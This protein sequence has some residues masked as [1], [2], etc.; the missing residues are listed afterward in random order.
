MKFYHK[1][2][3]LYVRDMEG[4]K[5][6]IEGEYASPLIKMLKDVLWVFT[7]KIDGTNIGIHWDGNKVSYIGRTEKSNIPAYLIN[8]LDELFA[9]EENE[10]VFEQMFGEQKVTLFGEGYGGKIQ[11]GGHYGKKEDFIL[12]DV[13]FEEKELWAKR[14]VVQEIAKALNIGIV[15]I[16]LTGTL[17]DGV[18]YVKRGPKSNYSEKIMEGVVGRPVCEL[19]DAQGKRV[20]VKIKGRDFVKP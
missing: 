10:Q 3:T 2:E 19:K 11:N 5:K 8:R 6:L 20:I 14:G 7:E 9:G 15:P 4:T 1:I 13:F 12:F 16:V 18:D 17:Q